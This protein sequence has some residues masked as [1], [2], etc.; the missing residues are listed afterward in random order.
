MVTK[1][2]IWGGGMVLVAKFGQK[3]LIQEFPA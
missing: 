2:N 3:E 1:H